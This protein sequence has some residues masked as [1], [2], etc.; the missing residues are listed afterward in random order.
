[1]EYILITG[2]STGIGY[3]AAKNLI[4]AGY[5]ITETIN[6]SHFGHTFTKI[7]F[8]KDNKNS[9]LHLSNELGIAKS[10]IYEEKNLDNFHDLTLILGQNHNN[11]KS[12]KIVQGFNPFKK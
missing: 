3:S 2:V 1:M 6:A 11:L 5:D 12:H 9:A 10:E 7:L 4:D 8:H